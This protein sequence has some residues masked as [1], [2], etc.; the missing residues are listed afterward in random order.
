MGKWEY[1]ENWD[2]WNIE[3]EG[4][5]MNNKGALARVEPLGVLVHCFANV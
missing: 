1:W 3:L 2:F 4:T 5:T